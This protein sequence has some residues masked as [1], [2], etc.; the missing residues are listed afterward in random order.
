V[1]PGARL[2]QLLARPGLVVAPACGTPLSAL[3]ARDEGFEAVAL[4]GYT[5]GA[6]TA[7]TEPLFTMAELVEATRRLTAVLDIPVVVDGG[8]GFGEPLHTMRTIRELEQVGA[9]A[10][11]IEDQI[12]PKRAHYHREY[13]EHV[14]PAEDMVQK[15]ACAVRARRDPGFVI[16]AR[17]D[18]I[19]THGYEE[20][21]R[22]ARAYAAAGADMVMLFP[23]T[24][25]EARRAPR[26]CGVPLVYVNSTGNRT[27]RPFYTNAE[28]EALGYRMCV[29]AISLTVA[30]Y[31]AVRACLAEIRRTGRSGIDTATAREA[32]LAVERLIGL[33]E[34]YRIEESTV[35]G[36]GAQ[37]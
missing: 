1:T 14:I 3:I 35:E 34:H 13:R 4:G 16:I 23:R 2:R 15:V 12:F 36:K 20:G 28:L 6:H 8:A 33:E 37:P 32:R 5:L 27:G 9:A 11:H 7:I 30:T 25:D 22:R 31:L 18:A 24:D 21:V 29:D 17:T 19:Q 10:V 26:D